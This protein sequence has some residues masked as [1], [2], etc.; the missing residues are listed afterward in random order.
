MLVEYDVIKLYT[1]NLHLG[2][3]SENAFWW[4]KMLLTCGR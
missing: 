1:K 4:S 3:V 2:T